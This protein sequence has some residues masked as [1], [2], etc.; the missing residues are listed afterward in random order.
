MSKEFPFIRLLLLLLLAHITLTDR[1]Y[2]CEPH[3]AC[4]FPSLLLFLF[5]YWP[6]RLSSILLPINLVS[7]YASNLPVALTYSIVCFISFGSPNNL[8]TRI[9]AVPTSF[10]SFFLCSL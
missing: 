6:Y 8:A 4:P 3:H 2:L 9:L 5:L 7:F 1:N 10:L